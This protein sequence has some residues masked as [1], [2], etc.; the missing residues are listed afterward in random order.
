MN[1]PMLRRLAPLLAALAVGCVGPRLDLATA[2]A[3]DLSHGFG[4]RT[5][6][7]PTESAGFQRSDTF[8]GR[9]PAGFYYS[10][11]KFAAPEHGGTH[12]DAPRHFAEGRQAADEVPLERLIG[13]AWVL[14]AEEACAREAD[15]LVGRA[16]YDAAVRRAGPPPERAIVLVRTGWGR[17]WPDRKAYLGDDRP[18]KTDALSFP[19]LDPAL[20][21]DLVALG[22]RA[23]G[24]DTASI[25]RGRSTTF[26][27]HQV[28]AAANVPVFE[29]V[30]RLDELPVRGAWIVAAPMKI[31]GGTGGPLRIYAFVPGR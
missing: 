14:D 17:R 27:A 26:D 24:I 10:A 20:G 29:N 2:R 31:E 13:P 3:V 25:D 5:L 8:A 28:L 4:A 9:T 22:V 16:D 19:G 11:G 1:D 12:L 7:W 23:I 18:G 6:Y 30:A 21:R 15:H